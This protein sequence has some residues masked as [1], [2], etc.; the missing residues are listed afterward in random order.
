M[1]LESWNW[2][3]R[4]YKGHFHLRNQESSPQQN[5]KKHVEYPLKP[6]GYLKKLALQIAYVFLSNSR[7]SALNMYYRIQKMHF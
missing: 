1:E 2:F 4:Q 6:H 5:S 7:Q 3:Q